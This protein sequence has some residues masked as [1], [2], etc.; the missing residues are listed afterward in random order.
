MCRLGQHRP[1][2]KVLC[3]GIMKVGC[4]GGETSTED[5]P[6]EEMDNQAQLRMYAQTCRQHLGENFVFVRLGVS[7]PPAG[8]ILV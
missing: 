1:I 4:P 5:T 3:D 2:C 7:A 6:T 8:M